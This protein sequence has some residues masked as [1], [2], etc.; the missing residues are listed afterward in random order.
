[1]R[2]PASV[3]RAGWLVL[4]S[5]P[6]RAGA[7][8]SATG[9]RLRRMRGILAEP[10]ERAHQQLPRSAADKHVVRAAARSPPGQHLDRAPPLVVDAAAGHGRVRGGGRVARMSSAA[11]Y[12]YPG[13]CT[14]A[15]ETGHHSAIGAGAPSPRKGAATPPAPPPAITA[16]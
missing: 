3:G 2:P 5:W 8:R 4:V 1:M 12:Q 6:V 14:L 15:L 13:T 9:A 11:R 7:C 10:A 16:T